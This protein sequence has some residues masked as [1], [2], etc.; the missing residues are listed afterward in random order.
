MRSKFLIL[1]MLVLSIALV[2]Q[3]FGATLTAYPTK[4]P[5]GAY[6][7]GPGGASDYNFFWQE[8]TLTV[9]A[10]H[11]D[12]KTITIHLPEDMGIADPDGDDDYDEEISLVYTQTAAYTLTPTDSDPNT[13]VLVIDD[14][15]MTDGDVVKILFPVVTQSA[16]AYSTEDYWVEFEDNDTDDIADGSGQFITFVDPGPTALSLVTFASNLTANDDSTSR[17]GDRFPDA[18]APTFGALP[19]FVVD[20]GDAVVPSANQGTYYLFP[21]LDG[22]EDGVESSF[23]VWIST[24]SN[25]SHVDSLTAGVFKALTYPGHI[26]YL[27]NEGGTGATRYDMNGYPEGTYYFYITNILTGDF[28]LARSDGLVVRHWPVINAVGYDHDHDFI[29]EPGAG[30]DDQDLTLDTGG[31]YNYEG[32]AAGE[33]TFNKVDIY[34]NVDDLDD[35]AKIHLF[36]S[37]NSALT[38]ANITTTGSAGAGTLAIDQLV[39]GTPIIKNL[40]ENSEDVQGF[41]RNRWYVDPDS[42]GVIPAQDLTVYCVACDGKHFEM[43]KLSG[44]DVLTSPPDIL[45]LATPLITHI[46]HSPRLQIDSMSEYDSDTGTPGIQIDVQNHDQLMISWGKSGTNGDIDTDDNAVIDFYLV[47]D[48]TGANMLSDYAHNEATD[49]RTYV[50]DNPADAVK[51]NS[52]SIKEALEAK[53]QSWF[54]WDLKKFFQE[55]TWYPEEGVPYTLYGIISENKATN[56]AEIVYALTDTYDSFI[57]AGEAVQSLYFLNTP[58]VRLDLPPAD[59]VTINAEETYRLPFRAFDWDSDGQV[60]IFIVKIDPDDDPLTLDGFEEGPMTTTTGDLDAAGVEAYDLTDDDGD[61]TT[62]GVYLSENSATYYDMTLR[63]T[64]SPDAVKY[65]TTMNS[66]GPPLSDGTYWVYIGIDPDLTDGGTVPFFGGTETLYRAPGPLTVVNTL[67]TP[68]QRNLLLS[69]MEANVAAGD[70]LTLTLKGADNS[71]TINRI[72]AFVSVD[73][74][75]WTLVN[76][77]TPFTAATAYSGKLLANTVIDDEDNNRWILRAVVFDGVAGAQLDLMDTGPG[78]DIASFQLVSK[79]TTDAIQHLTNVEFMNDPGH[80]WVTKFSYNGVDHSI[81]FFSSTV[82]VVPRAIIEGIVELQ[83]RNDMNAKFTFELRERGGYAPITDAFFSAAND[84][85]AVLSGLQIV[86]NTN[87]KF[88]LWKVPTG[89][90]DLVVKYDRYLSKKVA[91]NV[92]PGED[93]LFVSFGQLLGGDCYGYS[94]S[95]NYVYPD[96]KIVVGDLNRMATAF[97]ATS[98]TN[99]NEWDD[100]LNN[101]KWADINEDGIVEAD[102][103]SLTT[104]NSGESGANPVYK[105]VAQPGISNTGTVVEFMNVPSE[106]KAGDTYTIQVVARNTSSVRAYFVNMRYDAAMLD[107]AGIQKGGFIEADSYSFPVI[108]EST[109]GLANSAFG[110]VLTNGDGVLAEVSFTARANGMF[111]AN[112]LTF[113]KI[114]LVNGEFM[115]ENLE[116]GPGSGI[117]GK[118]PITFALGQNYPNPF[119]PTTVIGFTVPESGSVSIMVYD[120]LGRHVRT[121]VSQP[122]QVGLHSVVWDGRDD[123][124]SMVS[125]GVYVYTIKSGKY[126]A[127]KKMLFMK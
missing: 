58:F 32:T 51:I 62:G 115:K 113:D 22:N 31:Y 108:G 81:N 49:I 82:K 114:S 88:T 118:N 42:V 94:D 30:F 12:T 10:A 38:T 18:A 76:A 124:G 8:L 80:S 1:T 95:L 66:V 60:G 19:D 15:N 84:A 105:P 41:V 92:Y 93:I 101:W 91:V 46:K 102:D 116:S 57:L 6:V 29:Y 121:L 11:V 106:L 23:T 96:N 67:I 85:D 89:E 120:V 127:A 36:Y 90:Y 122:Y 56:N 72:D 112:M 77:T 70:T 40:L 4:V 5:K 78:D 9:G 64:V 7:N 16:P 54:T 27:Q 74:T 45:P 3:A 14:N 24:Q 87:G 33:D 110:D 123:S 26:T 52:V 98:A 55:N 65:T 17:K 59:G 63:P 21:T 2:G 69:P 39:G 111:D 75:W 83:G 43:V 100:G 28:P 117:G 35:N 37:G 44:T 47:L 103:L 34:A 104:A 126:A 107:F 125:A 13:I 97:L 61:Y 25:L 50:T 73:K 68:I 20:T 86:P 71:A 99:P 119:N 109:V 79:G 53:D 48:V